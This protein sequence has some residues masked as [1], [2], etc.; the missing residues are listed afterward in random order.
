MQVE[1]CRK[2]KKMDPKSIRLEPLRCP[3]CGDAVFD[4]RRSA[5]FVSEG[6]IIVLI[7]ICMRCK[8]SYT[9]SDG[10]DSYK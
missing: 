2:G 4:I 10:G 1:T 9:L 8:T 5:V 7:A 3:Y 6:D